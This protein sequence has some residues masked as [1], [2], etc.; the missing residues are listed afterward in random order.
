MGHDALGGHYPGTGKG[1][2]LSA[3]DVLKTSHELFKKGTGVVQ[4]GTGDGT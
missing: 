2:M 3:V 1:T 4:K